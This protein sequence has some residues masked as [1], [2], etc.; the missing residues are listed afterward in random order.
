MA[1]KFSNNASALLGS[2]LT[3]VATSLSLAAGAGLLFPV[4]A[5]GDFFMLTLIKLV[6]G[7]PVY[8][9]VKVTARVA[10]VCT[11]VR[12]QEGT[13]ATTF[14]AG[15]RA[16]NRLTAS[17]AER[18]TKRF[19]SVLSSATPAPNVDTTD[20]YAITALAVPAA[21]G[22]PTGSPSDGQ[23]IVF[24]FKDNG[25]PRALTWNAAYR[26]TADIPLPTTTITS[27]TTYVGCI[28]NAVDLKWDVLAVA[29]NY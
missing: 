14:D 5:T 1:V 29:I 20:V 16:E 12:A 26:A 3:S 19:T 13:A 6:S 23:Q 25:A 22:A 9:I 10:D 24:R 17:V 21:I 2:P 18:M 8:E 7:S 28:Y 27:K 11:I 4:L 15:D